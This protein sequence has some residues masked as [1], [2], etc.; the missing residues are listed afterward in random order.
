MRRQTLGSK[1]HAR[2]QPPQSPASRTAQGLQAI[3]DHVQHLRRVNEKVTQVAADLDAAD[4]ANLLQA[5]AKRREEDDSDGS[6][7]S[8]EFNVR[9]FEEWDTRAQKNTV[10]RLLNKLQCD[11]RDHYLHEVYDNLRY[12][13]VDSRRELAKL[14]RV[15]QK[16][17][18]AFQEYNSVVQAL[19]GKL[20]NKDDRAKSTVDEFQQRLQQAQQ[21]QKQES[22]L[23]E[24]GA[25]HDDMLLLSQKEL[26]SMSE[27][28]L[29][30]EV[31]LIRGILQKKKKD[32]KWLM[33][34]IVPSLDE[35][36]VDLQ[37]DVVT[38]QERLL[39]KL[40]DVLHD[41]DARNVLLKELEAHLG[42]SSAEAR[43]AS[44]SKSEGEP[45]LSANAARLKEE[46][47]ADIPDRLLPDLLKDR[48]ADHGEELK[49]IDTTVLD[50][51]SQQNKQLGTALESV[52]GIMEQFV[53][54]GVGIDDVRSRVI[55][56]YHG[57]A[58]PHQLTDTLVESLREL[59]LT[60]KDT[61]WETEV[62]SEAYTTS[63]VSLDDI[64]ELT[65][66]LKRDIRCG[67]GDQKDQLSTLVSAMKKA[68]Q[69]KADFD[70]WEAQVFT[71]KDT[72][73]LMTHQQQLYEEASTLANGATLPNTSEREPS[74]ATLARGPAA[75]AAVA[76]AFAEAGAD[77][78]TDDAQWKDLFCKELGSTTDS[79]TFQAQANIVDALAEEER[80]LLKDLREAEGLFKSRVQ[81][82]SSEL[83]GS[84]E[85]GLIAELEGCVERGRSAMEEFRAAREDLSSLGNSVAGAVAVKRHNI[86]ALVDARRSAAKNA[87][88]MHSTF[89]AERV[90]GVLMEVVA[91]CAENRH[92]CKRISALD[93]QINSLRSDRSR[94]KDEATRKKHGLKVKAEVQRIKKAKRQSEKG[95]AE[96]NEEDYATQLA[97]LELQDDIPGEREARRLRQGRRQL[98]AVRAQAAAL[99][100]ASCATITG[101]NSSLPLAAA[102]HKRSR[103]TIAG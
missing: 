68:E 60:Q 65:A 36:A 27:E 55:A 24:H 4:T 20:A 25:A 81:Q 80:L 93:R 2:P 94:L 23:Y 103:M 102:A 30:S 79:L 6:E 22:G 5:T 72:L 47:G 31:Q 49:P 62:H 46:L 87:A 69:A 99:S 19:I 83:R 77:L 58:P 90:K 84:R 59:L 66:T 64:R 16:Q 98:D 15:E 7:D 75:T 100:S 17:D 53:Q 8:L 28:D 54:P 10:Y 43:R 48:E 52:E 67:V 14:D 78:G 44:G 33:Q 26:E 3:H 37:D 82:L 61:D 101:N 63:S 73:N 88:Y 76:A 86:E 40:G 32:A 35:F 42:K 56:A 51:M 97:E 91:L 18:R 9:D 92:Y 95:D 70:K 45:E 13:A 29:A 50:M 1:S 38:Q 21:A 12:M 34:E 71:M 11:K 57:K 39:T 41:T 85:E 96:D 89:S 74:A